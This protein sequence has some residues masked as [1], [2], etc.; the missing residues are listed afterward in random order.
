MLEFSDLYVEAFTEFGANAVEELFE[1]S[2][3]N[4]VIELTKRLAA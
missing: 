2:E 4:E 3:I 1:E